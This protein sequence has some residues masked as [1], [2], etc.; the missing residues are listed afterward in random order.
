MVKDCGVVKTT[1]AETNL[2]LETFYLGEEG[3]LDF[4]TDQDDGF[5]EIR[6]FA[7]AA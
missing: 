6:T 4:I 2:A 1:N 5:G 3:E 7:L